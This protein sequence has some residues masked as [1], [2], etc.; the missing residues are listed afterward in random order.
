MNALVTSGV[1]ERITDVAWSAVVRQSDAPTPTSVAYLA[2]LCSNTRTSSSLVHIFRV[3]DTACSASSSNP[4]VAR[5]ELVGLSIGLDWRVENRQSLLLIYSRIRVLIYALAQPPSASTCLLA[6]VIERQVAPPAPSAARTSDHALLIA[7]AV[8]PISCCAWSDGASIGRDGR[9][10]APSV[11][12]NSSDQRRLLLS[13]DGEVTVYEWRDSADPMW[14]KPS[15]H[16]M[17]T[18]GAAFQSISTLSVSQTGGVF[19]AARE[20]NEPIWGATADPSSSAR[21][22][23]SIQNHAFGVSIS[24]VRDAR[25]VGPS[26]HTTGSTRVDLTQA[27]E[28]SDEDLDDRLVCPDLNGVITLGSVRSSVDTAITNGSNVDGGVLSSLL[29]IEADDDAVEVSSKFLVGQAMPGS[30]FQTAALSTRGHT[31]VRAH[32]CSS[33]GCMPNCKDAAMHASW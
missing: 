25:R 28:P 33:Q 21:A 19:L 22:A 5:I 16:R 20:T 14:D 29:R 13:H 15:V 6:C 24:R 2:V 4:C 31:E 9:S 3:A 12:S 11:S 27:S 7:Q 8:G 23:P 30:S 1:A 32:A 18:E 17:L 26:S 10:A